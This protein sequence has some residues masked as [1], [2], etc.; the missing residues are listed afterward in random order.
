MW[1]LD[2]GCIIQSDD[3]N[4]PMTISGSLTDIN[5]RKRLETM[6]QDFIS[7]VSHELR[8]PLT[9]ICGSLG[10]IMGG[11]LGQAPQTMNS[12]LN[13]AHK[14]SLRLGVLINDLLDMEKLSSGKMNFDFQNY[15]VQD[16]LQ[17]A[18]ESNTPY[19]AERGI[20]IVLK[21]PASEHFVYVDQLRFMQV[22]SNLLSNAIKYSPEQTGS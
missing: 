22:L 10:L 14:N 4:N 17:S 18:I 13:I 5:E 2:R 1:V 11:A 8:T 20:R 7:T 9:S 3:Q 15:A 21:S 12:I 6:K 16:L 19:G